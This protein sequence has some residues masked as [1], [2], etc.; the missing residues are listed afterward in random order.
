MRLVETTTTVEK[1]RRSQRNDKRLMDYLT[2]ETEMAYSARQG[3]ETNW[4]ECLRQ[5][6]GVP[7]NPYKAIPFENAPNMEVTLGAIAT[8][9][10]Y[11]QSLTNAFSQSPVL[12]IRPTR[13][14]EEDKTLV[15]ASKALEDFVEWAVVN[16]FNLR[17]ACE[18]SFLDI[19][20]LGTGVHY[21]PYVEF[22]KK[23][24][25]R[26]IIDFGPRIRAIPPEDFLAPSGMA[27]IVDQLPWVDLRFYMTKGDLRNHTKDKDPFNRWETTNFKPVASIDYMRQRR[28]R[29]GRSETTDAYAKLYEVHKTYV[30]F[31]YDNDGEDEELVIIWDRTTKEIAWLNYALED[32]RPIEFGVYQVRSHQLPGLGVMEMLGTYQDA[33]SD[34][35]NDRSTNIKLANMR[36]FVSRTGAIDEGTIAAWAGRNIAV[37]NPE[38]DLKA[39]ELGEVY[40]SAFTNDTVIVSMAER[41]C[42][43]NELNTP[44][45][46]QVLGSRT[47]AF[48][49]SALLQQQSNRFAPAFDN[50]RKFG[51]RSVVQCLW[52]YHE[53]LLV[54][55]DDGPCATNIRRV[56]G[57]TRGNL[58]IALLRTDDFIQNVSVEMT[59]STAAV[60]KDAEK[61]NIIMLVNLIG[62]YYQRT[63]DLLNVA[64]SPD[65][66]E[67]VKV[68]AKEIAEKSGALIERAVRTFD[69]IRDPHTFILET[70][71]ALDKMDNVQPGTLNQLLQIL[72]QTA[73]QGVGGP[74]LLGNG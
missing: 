64:S 20:Q 24:R 57:D 1:L 56:M 29:M 8:D 62:S 42:G 48:T 38:S 59:A 72:A 69:N 49:T 33:L 54:Q 21:S 46:S 3:Q 10:L 32:S 25:Y 4:I 51:A 23:T 19:V 65:A 27:T 55:L 43:I 34:S 71:D 47:P 31:D 11:A 52:R 16:E 14:A 18:H 74:A 17:E 26:K 36:F 7:K 45:P 15:E 60:S 2:L 68:L 63:L 41:R 9:A 73:Q 50:M 61:Q 35:F 37:A 53:Q 40:P 30:S 28:E 13:R 22:T 58:V 67:P 6:E 12:T 70:G 44:R 66:P 5:Y 39:V